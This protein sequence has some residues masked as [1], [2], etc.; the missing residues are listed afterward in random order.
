M[1]ILFWPFMIASLILSLLAMGLKKSRFLFI[2]AIL[3]IP[4]SLYLA[5]TPRFGV[6]G[7]IFPLLFVGAALSLRKRITWLSI[8]LVLPNFLLIGWLA[9]VVLNQ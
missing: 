3:I 5:A 2:S 6:W 4:S 8:L 1:T 9:F 7:L